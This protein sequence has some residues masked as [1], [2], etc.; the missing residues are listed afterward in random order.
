MKSEILLSLIVLTFVTSKTEISLAIVR[1][2]DKRI[3][4]DIQYIYDR[5]PLI[6]K[7]FDKLAASELTYVIRYG[8]IE[9]RYDAIFE[10]DGQ[11]L[12]LTFSN[13][14]K[15]SYSLQVSFAHEATHA[16]QFE[17]GQIGFCQKKEGVWG[18]VNID[19][20]DEV[21]AFK[22]SLEVADAVDMCLG[23]MGIFKTEYE[24]GGFERAIQWLSNL[25]PRL[26]IEPKNNPDVI[27]L[28]MVNRFFIKRGWKL[29]CKAY[30]TS[31][32]LHQCNE[33][34]NF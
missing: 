25:Y 11:S 33:I 9:E 30:Q 4:E 10:T 12:F 14:K 5:Y 29:F 28:E 6:Q 19:L 7:Q 15:Y 34:N 20:W 2:S 1:F 27:H 13:Q 18:P 16:L 22:I 8:H 32:M 24:S 17:R 23:I 31:E 21:E 26:S 3:E